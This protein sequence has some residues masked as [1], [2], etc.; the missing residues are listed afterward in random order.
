[1]VCTYLGDNEGCNSKCIHLC[2]SVAYMQKEFTL[3]EPFDVA[4]QQGLNAPSE[5]SGSVHE[6][7][8]PSSQILVKK[9]DI[10]SPVLPLS[11]ASVRHTTL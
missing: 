8:S 10:D 11:G 3:Q 7:S 4:D 6:L 5:T 2:H 9:I 1:M